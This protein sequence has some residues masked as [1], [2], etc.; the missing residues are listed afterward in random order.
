MFKIEIL[1]LRDTGRPRIVSAVIAHIASAFADDSRH[2]SNPVTVTGLRLRAALYR[3][4][5]SIVQ[6]S[7]KSDEPNQL[8]LIP[9]Y[10]VYR[11]Y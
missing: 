6:L 11:S 3:S 8:V 4:L 1:R 7:W 9:T 10:F 2:M 5:A